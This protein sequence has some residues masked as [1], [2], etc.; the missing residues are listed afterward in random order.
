MENLKTGSQVQE[1][2]GLVP[3]GGQALR[4]APL[5]C[6]KELYPIG[7]RP[8][9]EGESVRPKVVCHYLLEKMQMAGVSK[10]YII[11]REGKW[12]IPAY[13]NDGTMLDMCLAY[14]MMRLPFGAPYTLDQAYP[15]VQD[16]LIVF[17]F[18]DVIFQP[19]DAFI[20]LLNRQTITKADIVLGLFPMDQPQKADMVNVAEDGQVHQIVIKPSKTHLR[21]AWMIAAWRP[22]FTKFMHQYIH[23]ENCKQSVQQKEL[24]LGDVIQA[25]INGG[26]NVNSVLFSD[27][28]CLD[29]GT[30]ENLMKA[31]QNMSGNVNAAW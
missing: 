10:T 30:P 12:D 20:Q 22:T 7:F 29:I 23:S 25:A 24:F 3:A 9:G 28:F 8:I 16:A 21:Y 4:I 19:N 6:S 27:D 2:I 26:L 31:V 11:L 5:P 15:F 17:G 18:P 13:F 14:L 1:V